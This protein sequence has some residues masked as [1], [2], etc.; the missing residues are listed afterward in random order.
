MWVGSN[1]GLHIHIQAAGE[2]AN[3]D[4]ATSDSR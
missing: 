1:D 4:V 3:P 2:E